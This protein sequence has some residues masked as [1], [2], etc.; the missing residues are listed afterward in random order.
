MKKIIT[1]AA[2]ATIFS[3]TAA[4]HEGHHNDGLTN[5]LA[6]LTANPDHWAGPLI[7]LAIAGTGY[8]WLYRRRQTRKMNSNG[9][10]NH[11]H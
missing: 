9:S 2:L 11:T 7:L 10:S 6:H 1:T 8:A 4:A 5:L 3:Q